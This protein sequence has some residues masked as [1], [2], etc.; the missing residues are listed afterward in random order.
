[1]TD[2]FP[3]D[4]K[5]HVAPPKHPQPATSG[6]FDATGPAT[7]AQPDSLKALAIQVLER[8]R[9]RNRKATAGEEPCNFGPEKSREK[10]HGVTSASRADASIGMGLEAMA[11]DIATETGLSVAEVLALLDEDDREAIRTG[12][13]SG[14]AEAWRCAARALAVPAEP[15]PAPA[16]NDF[17]RAVVVWTPSGRPVLVWA[18]SHEQAERLARWNPGPSVID[19]KGT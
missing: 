7:E 11:K 8:N 18:E 1:M 9:R 3:R 16:G 15:I 6:D 14:R 19:R 5:L 10:L 17:P 4:P 13:D 12:A 2:S